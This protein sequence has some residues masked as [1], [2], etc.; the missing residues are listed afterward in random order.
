[1]GV[2][3]PHNLYFPFAITGLHKIETDRTQ[4]SKEWQI[5]SCQNSPVALLLNYLVTSQGKITREIC[6]TEHNTSQSVC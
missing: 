5:S 1:M 4:V 6:V 3:S 2:Y